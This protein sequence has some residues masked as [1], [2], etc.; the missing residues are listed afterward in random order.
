MATTKK[1]VMAKVPEKDEIDIIIEEMSNL[2]RQCDVTFLHYFLKLATDKDHVLSA[3]EISEQLN[4]LIPTPSE[5]EG[6]NV[7][8]YSEKT[9]KRKLDALTSD[10]DHFI[11]ILE[12]MRIIMGGSIVACEPAEEK[13]KA[14]KRDPQKRFYFDPVLSKGDMNMIYGALESSRYLSGPEKEFLLKRLEVLMPTFE[15]EES[16]YKQVQDR[17][18]EELLEVRERPSDSYASKNSINN[19]TLLSNIQKIYDAIQNEYQIEITYGK[20]SYDDNLKS[21][22]FTAINPDKPYVINPYAMFW[23]NGEYYLIGTHYNFT[24]TAHFRV[25]RIIDVKKHEVLNK[26]TGLS[27][28]AKRRPIPDALKPFFTKNSVGKTKHFDSVAFSNRYP[29]MQ[30]H[31]TENLIDCTFEC[32]ERQLQMIIDNFGEKISIKKID[33][34]SVPV[35]SALDTEDNANAIPESYVQATIRKVQYQSA[36]SFAL[37]HARFITAI[38]PATLVNEVRQIADEIVERYTSV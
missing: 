14:V 23:N 7:S 12:L 25:D 21:L 28:L 4:T 37:G 38:A 3:A 29:G 8:F 33:T 31:A 5:G 10:K 24:N 6:A 35:S 11:E 20:Y 9:I 17:R 19:V 36:L 15:Y 22:T 18:L 13:S 16:S 34:P 2:L 32:T 27:E 30:I 1:P 26:K